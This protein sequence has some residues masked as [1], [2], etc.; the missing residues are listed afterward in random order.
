MRLN[1]LRKPEREPDAENN[2]GRSTS[3]SGHGG[4]R[5]RQL[6]ERWHSPYRRGELGAKHN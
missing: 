1:V 5:V 2:G 6:I 4:G 3:D